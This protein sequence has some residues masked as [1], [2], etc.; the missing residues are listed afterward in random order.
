VYIPAEGHTLVLAPENVSI[1]IGWK[2]ATDA[3]DAPAAIETESVPEPV[4]DPV[5]LSAKE[6]ALTELMNLGISEAT[7]RT[8]V[9]LPTQV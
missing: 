2:W 7:A 1:G 9:G 3:W 8:I 4:E 5:V 6:S